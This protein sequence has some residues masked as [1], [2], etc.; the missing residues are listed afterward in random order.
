MAATES[1]QKITPVSA[2]QDGTHIQFGWGD[3]YKMADIMKERYNIQT[4]L[5][6]VDGVEVIRLGSSPTDTFE[7]R[8]DILEPYF[9]HDNNPFFKTS[10]ADGKVFEKRDEK[11]Q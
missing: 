3:D 1:R 2:L 6:Y 11:R 5:N 9:R 10:V 4:N 8:R 7:S